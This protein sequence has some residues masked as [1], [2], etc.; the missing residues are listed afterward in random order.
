MVEI[1]SREARVTA[2]AVTNT[3]R[4]V[5]AAF[6]GPASAALLGAGMVSGIIYAGG[7]PKLVYDALVYA[8][9]RKRYR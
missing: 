2:N 6:G 5:G 4:S 8:T 9:Y 7:I 1:F 3:A